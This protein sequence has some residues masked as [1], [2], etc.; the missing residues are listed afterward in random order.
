[1]ILL[2]N[3]VHPER[4]ELP[5]T[6]FVARYSIQ[7]SYGC[8][9]R[10]QFYQIAIIMLPGITAEAQIRS[11]QTKLVYKL[12]KIGG[13]SLLIFFTLFYHTHRFLI[14]KPFCIL[15]KM[16]LLEKRNSRIRLIAKFFEPLKQ[17]THKSNCVLFT[18]LPNIF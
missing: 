11:Q 18:K 8:I 3:L 7:L 4:F 2:T 9:H 1:M 10:G 17:Y 13:F 12:T 6:W 15:N 14:L 5:T 16:F